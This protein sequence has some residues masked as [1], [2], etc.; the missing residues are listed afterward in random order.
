MRSWS[1][2]PVGAC[3]LAACLLD[4]SLKIFVGVKDAT[5]EFE[6]LWALADMAPP[7]HRLDGH[8][9]QLC[10][11]GRRHESL[12]ALHQTVPIVGI[13]REQRLDLLGVPTDG[14]LTVADESAACSIVAMRL[15]IFE[16]PAGLDMA[17]P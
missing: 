7:A 4:E 15:D 2:Y 17:G 13:G 14:S 10:D 1:S 9:E 16:F 3:L 5:A 12:G 11:F 6:R 8:P